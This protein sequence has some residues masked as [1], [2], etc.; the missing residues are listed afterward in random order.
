MLLK[1]ALKYNLN[2]I[3]MNDNN[4]IVFSGAGDPKIK[5]GG[6]YSGKKCKGTIENQNIK[7]SAF[8]GSTLDHLKVKRAILENCDFSNVT[9][10]SV[11]FRGAKLNHASNIYSA[12]F[13]GKNLFDDD[14]DL[15]GIDLE[16]LAT[17]YPL[18]ASDLRRHR[19]LYKFKQERKNI[20]IIWQL[21]CKCG[22]SWGRLSGIAAGIVL[23]FFILF[24]IGSLTHGGW[25]LPDLKNAAGQ[26]IN[27]LTC[28]Q[29]SALAFVGFNMPDVAWTDPW[30]GM[31]VILET[32]LGLAFIG[33]L[34]TVIATNISRNE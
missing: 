17:H 4:V 13:L 18:I 21:T 10:N 26:N 9:F 8:T 25:I 20:Y 1:M 7:N 31:Y 14:T 19:Y 33:I 15:E 12:T 6:D 27:L 30:T 23:L 5:E 29:F 34:I 16:R 22:R 3:L 2:P 24:I 11:D 28:F 32:W